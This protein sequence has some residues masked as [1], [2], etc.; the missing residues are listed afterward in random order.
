MSRKRKQRFSASGG[1]KHAIEPE[2]SKSTVA[3]EANAPSPTDDLV[4][5]I[6]HQSNVFWQR[7]ALP[8]IAII[9]LITYIGSLNT[10]FV[11][12]DNGQIVN[13]PLVHSLAH[14]PVLFAG[15]TFYNGGGLAP[16]TGLY[17]RPLMTT[18][19][20]LLYTIFG[21]H[22]F[23][24]H[25]FQLA[26]CIGSALL[27]YLFFRYSF[28]YSLALFL[29]LAFLI[30]P[31]D[32]Q[33]VFGIEA[34]QDALYFFFGILSVWLLLRF[35]SHRSLWLVTISLLLS[36]FSK[37]TGI[38]FVIM[39]TLYL[40]WFDRG[41]LRSFLAV[42]TVPLLTY[43]ILKIHAVGLGTTPKSAPI[44]KL[45][46][47]GRLMT[48][49]SILL[50][51]I[52]K[53]LFPLKLA[54]GYYWT[55]PTFSVAHVLLP[56]LIDA[57]V[58][59]GFV[60]LG[61]IV[62]RRASTPMYMTFRFFAVWTVVGLIAHLQF[63]PLDDTVNETWLYF[64][65]VGILG[66]FG[67]TLTTFPVA[68]KARWLMLASAVLIVLLGYRT[69][70]RGGDWNSPL[71][72]ARTDLAASREDYAAAD[73][74]ATYDMDNGNLMAARTFALESI[75]LNTQSA[76][77]ITMGTIYA[78][79]GLYDDA[80]SYFYQALKYPRSSLL[81]DDISRLTLFTGTPNANL[82][83]LQLMVKNFPSDP[84]PYLYLAI[85]DYAKLSNPSGA[86]A[87]IQSAERVGSGQ[88]I[89][90]A[91]Y[92]IMNNQPLPPDLVAKSTSQ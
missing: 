13:N 11:Y 88:L 30:H 79:M 86:R 18:V 47:V 19:Y 82:E 62:H 33:V 55:Y 87:A 9:G 61:K 27:V 53:F 6:S 48:M 21:A 43:L 54:T 64:S 40:W 59:A 69:M 35:S 28:K 37:E 92:A 57:A 71:G 65:M 15:S 45:N 5:K 12:D 77:L 14:I 34:L 29:A 26:V 41:R 76:N 51:Y 73:V 89:D 4:A 8:I 52:T 44:D 70:L 68:L 36:L 7:L 56:L 78:Q 90:Q 38:L 46:L 3:A 17:Y 23:Y 81:A 72:L 25:L 31:I 66:M 80:E 58:I 22:S 32:S 60:Y 50:F 75:K 2:E 85:L 74:I 16:L 63:I 67:A 20:A 24:F 1:H 10:P 49:P 42:F 83:T 84:N 91:A 39:D